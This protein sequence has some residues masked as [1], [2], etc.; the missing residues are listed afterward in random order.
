M[1]FG[2]AEKCGRSASRADDNAFGVCC[3]GEKKARTKLVGNG[4][5]MVR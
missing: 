2:V 4:Q 3:G 1:V 5:A